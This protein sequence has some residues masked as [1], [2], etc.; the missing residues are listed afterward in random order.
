[1]KH[2]TPDFLSIT[3]TLL[4]PPPIHYHICPIRHI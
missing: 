3:Y 4:I 1:M 2:P